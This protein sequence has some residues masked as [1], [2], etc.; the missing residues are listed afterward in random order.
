MVQQQGASGR[1]TSARRS[2]SLRLKRKK[3]TEAQARGISAPPPRNAAFYVDSTS[4]RARSD[5]RR[6]AAGTGA[7]TCFSR[8]TSL[9]RGGAIRTRKGYE[10]AKG[11]Y[12]TVSKEELEKITPETA[13]EMQILEFVKL[14]EVDPIY[15]E[16]SYYVTP[17]RAGERA[18]VFCSQPC[19][20]ADMSRSRSSRCTTANTSSWY[21]RRRTGIVLHTMFY[22]TEIRREDE[23][24]T[25]TSGVNEREL[26]LALMLVESLAAPFEPAKYHDSYKDE[27]RRN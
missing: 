19:S 5:S 26:Q 1:F 14:A 21:A 2:T 7:S 27:T 6:R 3:K 23:Y 15:F 12:V 16:T 9:A 13:R 8:R 17:D 25:D 4:Q 10:Y 11:Q 18:Y 22:E 20:G 24:R